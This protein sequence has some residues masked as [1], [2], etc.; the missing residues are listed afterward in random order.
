M[1]KYI[2]EVKAWQVFVVCLC[3]YLLVKVVE[4]IIWKMRNIENKR[5]A[6]RLKEERDR[7]L[8]KFGV[9]NKQKQSIMATCSVAELQKHL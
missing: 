7:K 6:K 9:V 3:A 2:F 8:F 4:L 5:H 1:I